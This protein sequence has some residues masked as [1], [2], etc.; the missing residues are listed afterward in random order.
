MSLVLSGS[1]VVTWGVNGSQ[2]R[3][4]EEKVAGGVVVCLFQ[5]SSAGRGSSLR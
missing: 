1:G 4:T 2:G 5:V 3:R